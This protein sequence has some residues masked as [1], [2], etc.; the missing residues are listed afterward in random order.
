[1]APSS[2]YDTP[3]D[4]LPNPRQVWVGEPGSEEEGLGKLSILTPELVAQTA[5]AEVKTGQRVTLQW[6][7]SKLEYVGLG[8]P[9]SQH[10]ILPLFGGMC[11]DDMYIFNPRE[12]L[13][14]SKSTVC[15]EWA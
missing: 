4:K 1:M 6:D 5:A 8:R 2:L 12:Y 15:R 14:S 7:L 11:F 9:N 3:F 10:H 13:I